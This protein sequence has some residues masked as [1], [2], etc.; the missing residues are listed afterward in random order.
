MPARLHHT[1]FTVSDVDAAERFFVDNFGMVRLG[2]GLYDFEYIRQIVGY[3]DAKLK[4]SVLGFPDAAGQSHRLE[5]IE[6]LAPTGEPVDTATCRPGAAHLC[7]EVDDIQAVYA[8][9]KAQ[10]VRFTSAPVQVTQ[11]INAGA[12]AVYFKGPSDIALELFQL[13]SR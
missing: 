4:I 3:P 1:S 6:Y 8:R 12:R 2:G 11:G 10:G 13:P 5:L 9:L 7:L